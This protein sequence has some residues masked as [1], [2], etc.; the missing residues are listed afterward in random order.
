[1]DVDGL[2]ARRKVPPKLASESD[3]CKDTAEPM[4]LDN[5]AAPANNQLHSQDV[6]V[7]EGF[8]NAHELGQRLQQGSPI[9]A[10]QDPQQHVAALYKEALLQAADHISAESDQIAQLFRSMSEQCEQAIANAFR[11]HASK[12]SDSTNAAVQAIVQAERERLQGAVAD[13]HEALRAIK[14]QQELAMQAAHAAQ[15]Q[16]ALQRIAAD[17]AELPLWP[18]EEEQDAPGAAGSFDSAEEHAVPTAIYNT[19]I[20][21]SVKLQCGDQRKS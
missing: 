13:Q 10:T 20:L 4:Q 14:R 16:P 18:D 5:A 2:I 17:P 7:S 1:M 19:T 11:P 21:V 15:Q 9:A 6:A 3:A 8:T 12:A